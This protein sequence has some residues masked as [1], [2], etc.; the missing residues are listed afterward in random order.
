M[1]SFFSISRTRLIGASAS[2]IS[3]QGS[4]STMV[5]SFGV[6]VMSVLFGMW[7]GASP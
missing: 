6:T 1:P 3:K 2:E 4:F 7:S 5:P